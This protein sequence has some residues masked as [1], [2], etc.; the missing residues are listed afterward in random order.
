MP[1]SNFGV[2]LLF[3]V[4]TTANPTPTNFGALQDVNVDFSFDEKQLH[5]SFQFALEQAR[6]K[7]K[8]TVKATIGRFDPVLFNQVMFGL[9]T[10]TGEKR[11]SARE[12]G[13]IPTT[14]FQITVA[15]G[16]TFAVDLGV[17]N[18]TQAKWMTRG[19]TAT[20]TGIYAVNVATGQYTF[21]TADTGNTVQ[22][23]YTYSAAGTGTT[24]TYTNQLMGAGAILALNLINYNPLTGKY[25]NLTYPAVQCF[26]LSAPMKLD[27]YTQVGLDFAAQD[28]GAGNIFTWT[29][30]G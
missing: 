22:F 18:V 2:G 1:G 25:L 15:N 27:D 4:P 21:N 17:Y 7:G 16:A 3:T 23:Y 13:S 10:S 6:G 5:G 8:A 19:A 20:G 12:A 30:T 29:M 11:N 24:L 9:T 26:K 28:D 14:P